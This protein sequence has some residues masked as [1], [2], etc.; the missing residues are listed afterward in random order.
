MILITL[1]IFAAIIL[2]ISIW[3]FGRLDQDQKTLFVEDLD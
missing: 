1:A 3:A 2:S